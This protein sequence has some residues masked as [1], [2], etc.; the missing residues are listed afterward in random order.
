M[1]KERE[2]YKSSKLALD[3]SI[4]DFSGKTIIYNLTIFFHHHTRQSMIKLTVMDCKS[5]LV[6]R[7]ISAFGTPQKVF[8]IRLRVGAPMGGFVLT[9]LNLI[10]I[11]ILSLSELINKTHTN[12]TNN[13]VTLSYMFSS[14]MIH[15][16]CIEK[17]HCHIKS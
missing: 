12:Y 17:S 8:L 16:T 9:I 4:F 6:L 1:K 13:Y 7:S 15:I 10:F 11:S 3:V 2:E 5:A 14:F